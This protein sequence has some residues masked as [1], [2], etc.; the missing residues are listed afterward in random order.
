[1]AMVDPDFDFA[2]IDAVITVFPRTH[3]TG[4][5]GGHRVTADGSTMRNPLINF[6]PVDEPPHSS[7]ARRWGHTA[8]HELVH[9]LGL[10]DYCPYDRSKHE[11]TTAPSGRDWV[12][13]KWGLFNLWAWFL[14]D[15]DD[16]RLRHTWR[17]PAG[18]TNFGYNTRLGPLEMLAW[19]RW[20]LGWL[21]GSQVRCI[22]NGAGS[23]NRSAESD[24]SAR[25]RCRDGRH[26]AQ[27]T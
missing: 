25:R 13:V 8:A 14:A 27:L 19:S 9:G 23:E 1:M 3:F 17:H 26:P 22:D 21:A 18:H 15:S 12:G 11:Q 4:A 10:V 2:D 24:R 7:D 16:R 5:V 20:Q 6:S